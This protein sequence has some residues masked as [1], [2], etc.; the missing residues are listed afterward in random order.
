MEFDIPKNH[1]G[2][3]ENSGRNRIPEDIKKIQ[4]YAFIEKY[5]I[6]A[7]GGKKRVQEIMLQAVNAAFENLDKTE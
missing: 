2:S 5:K 6:D 3:R 7:L 1:G 4:T